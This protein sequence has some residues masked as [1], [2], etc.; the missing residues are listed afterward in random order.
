MELLSGL[1]SAEL[2][3]VGHTA[4]FAPRNAELVKCDGDLAAKLMCSLAPV[5]WPSGGETSGE[6][7]RET[8]GESASAASSSAT[9][10]GCEDLMSVQKGL[11]RDASAASPP[12]T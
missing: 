2:A 7:S 3:S 4:H 9:I 1:C 11:D 12:P 8:S 5:E 6:T 10:E